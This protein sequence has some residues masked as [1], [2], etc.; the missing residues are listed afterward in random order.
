[1]NACDPVLMVSQVHTFILPAY[2]KQ[3]SPSCLP[4]ALMCIY[5][6]DIQEQKILFEIHLHSFPNELKVLLK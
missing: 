4:L 2:A 1:M 6:Y 5:K 3:S